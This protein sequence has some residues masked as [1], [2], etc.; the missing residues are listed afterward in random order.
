MTYC[1]EIYENSDCETCKHY[2]AYKEGTLDLEKVRE[3][4]VVE[5]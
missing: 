1:W 2:I 4:V 3:I 5:D